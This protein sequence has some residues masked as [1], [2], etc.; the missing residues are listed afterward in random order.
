MS[1]Q[2]ECADGVALI[3]MDD[4]KANALSHAMLQEIEAAF[5]KVEQEADAKVVVLAGRPGLFC[6]GFDTKVILGGTPDEAR[7]LF[8]RGGALLSRL[9]SYPRP[10]VAAAT[11]HAVAMGAF[12]LLCADYRVGAR[13]EFKLGF[14]ESAAGIDIPY[15]GVQLAQERLLPAYLT[16]TV[17]LGELFDPETAVAAG[18]LDQTVDTDKVMETA[19]GVG[20]LL[21]GLSANA[22]ANNKTALRRNLERRIKAGE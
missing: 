19:R 9:I 18:L 4:G 21:T 2:Y 10:L 22:V 11:G 7:A 12:L 15:M 16:R 3:Q 13:G 5:D 8:M 6:G 1:V 14:N 20:A 17:V